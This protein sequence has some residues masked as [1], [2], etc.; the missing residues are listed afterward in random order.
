MLL[1][2]DNYDSFVYNLARYLVELGCETRV[3]RNDAITVEGV[4]ELAPRA[5]IISPGPCT[6]HEAGVSIP[7]IRELSHAIPMLGVC[8]GHQAI[9]AA[10]GGDVIR[11]PKPVHGRTSLIQ[12]TGEDLFQDLPQ[13]LRVARYH[14]LIVDEQTLPSSLRVTARTEEGIPMALQHET[15]PLYGVQFHPESVL[16]QSGH[17]L[18]AN[19]LRLSA[20]PSTISSATNWQE[21]SAE[22]EEPKVPVVSW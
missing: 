8:L 4:A 6:P 18:L 17:Q 3:V 11:A 10:L 16:T 2:I 13:P 21:T 15:R 22:A 12:H 9:A 7:L 19:F 5:I 1:L 20:L 14:S